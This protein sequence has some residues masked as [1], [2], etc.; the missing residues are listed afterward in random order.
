[1][2]LDHFDFNLDNRL[3][4]LVRLQLLERLVYKSRC[5][6]VLVSSVDP[7]YYLSEGD[8]RSLADSPQ[9][10]AELLERWTRVMSAFQK[11]NFVDPDKAVFDELVEPPGSFER[12]R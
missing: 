1:M 12:S 9:L 10:A 2:A 5:R 11:V 3:D 4:N 7:V 6:V 8:S